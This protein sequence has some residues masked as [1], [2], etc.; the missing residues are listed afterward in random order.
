MNLLSRICCDV[1]RRLRELG[2]RDVR[3]LLLVCCLLNQ[4]T[5]GTSRLPTGSGMK[6]KKRRQDVEAAHPTDAPFGQL[7]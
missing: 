5:G 6:A 3:P 2:K 4:G 1:D 7:G